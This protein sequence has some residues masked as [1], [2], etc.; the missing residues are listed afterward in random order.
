M[1]SNDVIMAI[2]KVANV[3]TK[4]TLDQLNITDVTLNIRYLVEDEPLGNIEY[5]QY[6]NSNN[7][8]LALNEYFV[9][10]DLPKGFYEAIMT[11]WGGAPVVEDPIE[12]EYIVF[13]GGS[14]EEIVFDEDLQESGELEDTKDI[15]DPED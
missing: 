5:T 3:T 10:K 14:S 2:K 11:V 6:T 7:G 13:A 8:R 4:V 9:G 15:V 12:D 1:L